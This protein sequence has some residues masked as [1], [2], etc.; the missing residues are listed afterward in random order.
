MPSSFLKRCL[1]PAIP[2]I[3]SRMPHPTMHTSAVLSKRFRLATTPI[4]SCMLAV[5]AT[6]SWKP[7]ILMLRTFWLTR[8]LNVP[9]NEPTWTC[10]PNF[11]SII[12][13]ASVCY[14]VAIW[15][16]PP[17]IF[18]LVRRNKGRTPT[19]SEHPSRPSFEVHS[20]FFSVVADPA[21]RDHTAA[22]Q[23]V[24]SSSIIKYFWMIIFLKALLRDGFR[25]MVTRCVDDNSYLNMTDVQRQQHNLLQGPF[26]YTN[27]C[28]IFPP[29]TNWDL[30]P[31]EH[32]HPNV[33]SVPVFIVWKADVIYRQSI[34]VM[35]GVSLTVLAKSTSS[36]NSMVSVFI[37]YQTDW[38]FIRS[39]MTHSTIWGYGSRKCWWVINDRFLRRPDHTR[40]LSFRIIL[41]PILFVPC[42]QGFH[43]RFFPLPLSSLSQRLPTW[44]Y[45]IR[46]T[47]GSMQLSVEWPICR[48]L[49]GIWICMT[50]KW[51]RRG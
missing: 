27:F 25:C 15:C 5:W 37:D 49:L 39:F 13:F 36:P 50:E 47:S 7:P 29:S 42:A 17:F 21:P 3:K 23:S 48:V 1:F 6:Y 35:C 18:L 4:S 28:H 9:P 33:L 31:E 41:T 34:L 12:C 46:D 8:S 44:I 20:S 32:G 10:W 45:P 24:S 16:F 51:K 38:L 2:S 40:S 19:P 14:C 22:K 30:K 26:G 11:I 43:L